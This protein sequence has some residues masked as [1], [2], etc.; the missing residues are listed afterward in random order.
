MNS[1]QAAL[2]AA[3]LAEAPPKEPE[4][5]K[6][7]E[8]S[9]PEVNRKHCGIEFISSGNIGMF[10]VANAIACHSEFRKLTE[11]RIMRAVIETTSPDRLANPRRG[12][13]LWGYLKEN[14]P[15][16]AGGIE[17]EKI[18]EKMLEDPAL[19]ATITLTRLF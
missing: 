4:L 16:E 3:N 5:E 17:I 14:F 13:D 2:V 10:A 1:L 12:S 6:V 18:V 11:A 19:R 9:K 8:I 15:S 7:V